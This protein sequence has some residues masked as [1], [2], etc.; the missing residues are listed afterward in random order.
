M[1]LLAFERA[2]LAQAALDGWLAGEIR[3]GAEDPRDDSPA[4]VQGRAFTAFVLPFTCSSL[5]R[6]WV[7][8]QADAGEADLDAFLARHPQGAAAGEGPEPTRAIDVAA[9]VPR[10]ALTQAGWF[11]CHRQLPP[12]LP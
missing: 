10:V 11:G 12:R 4:A 8:Q 3:R 7:A 1:A 9:H 6:A 5:G 2:D